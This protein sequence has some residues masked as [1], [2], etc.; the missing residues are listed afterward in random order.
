LGQKAEAAAELSGALAVDPN[1]P[2]AREAL[3]R[4]QEAGNH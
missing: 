1:F 2:G 3:G 4:L